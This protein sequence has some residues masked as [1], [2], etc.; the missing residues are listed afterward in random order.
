MFTRGT[1]WATGGAGGGWIGRL[2]GS[3]HPYQRAVVDEILSGLGVTV[4]LLAVLVGRGGGKTTVSEVALLAT[5]GLKPRAKC[6]FVTDT[7]EHARDIAWEKFKD[8]IG[9]LGI[10]ARFNETRLTITF[11]KNGSTLKL[12]GAD[13][14]AAVEKFRGIPYDA[15]V[16]DEAASWLPLLL[17]WFID[18]GIRPRL[19]ERHGW[20]L[21]IG[22]PGHN[23]AGPFYEATRPGGNH[24]PYGEERSPGWRGWSSHAWNVADAAQYV[25]AIRL[26]WAEALATKAEKGWT[27]D[28]PVWLREYLG[29]WA[30]DATNAMYKFRAFLE[31]GKTAWN[32]WE[33]ERVGPLKIAKLPTDRN[34]WMWVLSLDRGYSDAFAINGFAF[35]PSDPSKRIYH[36]LC[37]EQKQLYARK[38]AC[39]LLGVRDT[40]AVQAFAVATQRVDDSGAPLPEP[41]MPDTPDPL[42][43]YGVLGYPIG[44]V[45][46]SDQSFIDELAKVYGVRCVQAK[47]SRDEKHGAI[48]LLNGDLV[49]GRL[50]VLKGSPLEDQMRSLQW[51]EDGFGMLREPKGE[52]DG[53]SD[54]ATYGRKLIAHLFESGAVGESKPVKTTPDVRRA[55]RPEPI[56]EPATAPE[57]EWLSALSDTDYSED[58]PW[59]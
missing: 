42:S 53:S 25:E 58:A 36:V 55:P 15:V 59:P 18:R 10:E 54:T 31:D 51:V 19:G 45:C 22:S 27:D 50:K 11:A 56:D 29:L 30:R 9:K 24:S 33:P 57:P 8:I 47:R 44:G 17:E 14:K 7:K 41:R 13:D 49:E 5:M 35:S 23:L 21:M 34:D 3:C 46:D 38:V 16:I 1:E 4:M 37:H 43:P 26:N 48:E 6:L 39:L 52:P 40:D 28:N 2:L 32:V 12:A 20:I